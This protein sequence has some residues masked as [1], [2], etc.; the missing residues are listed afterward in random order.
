[1]DPKIAAFRLYLG[2]S[3]DGIKGWRQIVELDKFAS[4]GKV[5]TDPKHEA[6]LLA[7][8]SATDGDFIMIQ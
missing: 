6:I 7:Y 2:V 5:W 8:E 1:M 4:Q 3:E